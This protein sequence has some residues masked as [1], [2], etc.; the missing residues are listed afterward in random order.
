MNEKETD[1]GPV[2]E[3]IGSYGFIVETPVL[4]RKI[5]SM[6]DTTPIGVLHIA[7]KRK[8]FKRYVQM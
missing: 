8:H 3:N 7:P 2:R 1:L 6:I 4:F 5:S